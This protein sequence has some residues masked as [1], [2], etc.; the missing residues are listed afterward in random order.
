MK[1]IESSVEMLQEE[2]DV[3]ATKDSEF[4]NIICGEFKVAESYYFNLLSIGMEQQDARCVLPTA[5]KTE[6]S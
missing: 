5:L 3:N 6:V 2:F 1:A 4:R